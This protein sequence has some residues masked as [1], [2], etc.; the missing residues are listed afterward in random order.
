MSQLYYE[1]E[2]PLTEVLAHMEYNGFKIDLE[3]LNQLGHEFQGELDDLT[4]GIFQLA[5]EE[6]NINSPKQIGEI[7]FDKLKLPVIKRTKTGYSTDAEVLDKLRGEHEIIEKILKYR[8]MVKLK[9]TYI[10]GLLNLVDEEDTR[11]HSTFNQTITNTGRISS[12]EPNLQN[13]PIRTEEGRKIRKAFV[14][15]NED[16]ILV[17]GDYSQI[18]LRVLAHISKDP[19]LIDAF[20][21]DLDIHTKTASQVFH[22]PEE[23]MTPLM[24]DRA[25]A[26]NFGIIYGISDYGLSKD[27]NISRKEAKQYIDN[28]LA[29]YKMVKKYMEDIVKIGK[30]KGYVETIF[31]RRRY[32]P[33]LKARNYNVR[34]FGERIAMNTPIQGSAADIIKVAMVKVFEELRKRGLKSKLILQVHDELIIEAHKDEEEEVKSLMKD[35]MEKSITL[36]IPLKVDLK[37]GDNWYETQ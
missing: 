22:I 2:L 5:G 31:K 19:K 33:E 37:V 29:N 3:V 17:D 28:Y 20:Y 18:E 14:P 24:R 13:I 35:I 34:S 30:E 21:N 10:D 26:V 15:K 8:Q 9:S 23:E 4:E 7:L 12:T 36:D 11:I 25:K 6:F 1:V 16:Y 32:I 27:L